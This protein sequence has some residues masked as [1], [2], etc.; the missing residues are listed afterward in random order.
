MQITD[1][2][3]M[4]RAGAVMRLLDEQLRNSAPDEITAV[5][6]ETY[7]A[8]LASLTEMYQELQRW[9]SRVSS[10]KDHLEAARNCLNRM[11]G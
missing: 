4:D 10:A 1:P 9:E 2:N 11:W 8:A 6:R 3:V 5:C 7:A